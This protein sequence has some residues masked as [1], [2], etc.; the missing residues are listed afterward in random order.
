MNFWWY[1]VAAIVALLL[2][3]IRLRR[4]QRSPII[5]IPPLPEEE[6][7]EREDADV[8]VLPHVLL[9]APPGI[10]KTTFSE[11]IHAELQRKLGKQINFITRIAGQ[12]R[13]GRDVE[14]VLGEIQPG[15][16]VF[17]DEIASLRLP[18]EELLYSVLQDFVFYPKDDSLLLDNNMLIIGN[19]GTDVVHVP[20]CTFIAATTNAGGI[21]RPLRERF[22]INI[23]LERIGESDLSDMAILQNKVKAEKSF[24]NYKG[25]E[26]AKTII[27][28]HM[29]ALGKTI[30]KVSKAAADVIAK[31]AM[32]TPRLANNYVF[33]SK[34]RAAEIG[35]DEVTAEDADYAMNL[36]GIDRHGTDRLDRRVIKFLLERDNRP[37]GLSALANAAGCSKKDIEDMVLPKLF[38]A[39]IMTRDHR[40]WACLSDVA[41]INYQHL[42]QNE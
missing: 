27:W 25:Q 41:L 38:A 14:E 6:K 12:L 20:K 26:T 3:Q 35:H 36:I 4:E 28:M 31:R 30:S 1:F 32:G 33:H 2:M 13:S 7:R 24:A 16:V 21:S 23:E 10:G 17:I 19:S 5:W 34:A 22:P 15:D 8:H 18:V 40:S 29:E 9:Y 42:I 39:K 11:V 37:V